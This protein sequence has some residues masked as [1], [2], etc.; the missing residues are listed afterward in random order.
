MCEETPRDWD[1]KKRWPTAAL[2]HTAEEGDAQSAVFARLDPPSHRLALPGKHARRPKLTFVGGIIRPGDR[3][4]DAIDGHLTR[5][6]EDID[7]LLRGI[8]MHWN[9][10]AGRKLEHAEERVLSPLWLARDAPDLGLPAGRRPGT[11]VCVVSDGGFSR[12]P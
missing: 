7:V 12:C 6:R 8:A 3:A 10:R 4:G 1:Q 11:A 2:R 5:A 9:L